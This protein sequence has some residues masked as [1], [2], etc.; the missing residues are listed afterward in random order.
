[1]KLRLVFLLLTWLSAFVIVMAL[2]LAFGDELRDFP[3][4]LRA[5]VISGVLSVSMTQ[6]V[7]P[8]INRFLRL[9]ALRGKRESEWRA[10][11]RHSCS[12]QKYRC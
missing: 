5:L 10:E 6:V 2:F 4:A 12:A 3:L 11:A 8:L 9:A 7:V 1:M